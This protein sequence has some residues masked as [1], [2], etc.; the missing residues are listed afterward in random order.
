MGE[1]S[2]G[3]VVLLLISVHRPLQSVIIWFILLKDFTMTTPNPDLLAAAQAIVTKSTAFKIYYGDLEQLTEQ[4]YGKYIE[5][6]ESPNDTTHEFDVTG[7][8]DKYDE[9]TLYKACELGYLECY[10][11]DVILNDLVR[12]GLIE[13]GQYLVRVSW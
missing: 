6:L 3:G 4:V 10:R 1:Y 8:L 13:P 7:Q 5:M 12:Q 2:L 11:Y 9:Q